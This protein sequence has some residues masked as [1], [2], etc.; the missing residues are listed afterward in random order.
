[1]Y[2]NL[3]LE[4]TVHVNHHRGEDASDNFRRR[5]GKSYIKGPRDS[6]RPHKVWAWH[7][8]RQ[9]VRAL[10]HREQGEHC[11]TMSRRGTYTGPGFTPPVLP[12]RTE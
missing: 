8:F 10:L 1:M 5:G 7:R 12:K 9:Y 6:W 4:P 11:P 2:I 3:H